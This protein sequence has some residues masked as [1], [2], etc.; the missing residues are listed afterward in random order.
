M[1]G[2]AVGL[3]TKRRV[4]VVLTL[5]EGPEPWIRVQHA[6][7][8]F[9]VPAGVEASELLLGALEGWTSQ[10]GRPRSAETM[11]RVPL[12]EWLRRA[13]AP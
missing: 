9:K 3:R 11:V 12:S 6:R 4:Q 8:W 2:V 10:R 1:E 7:G 13:P 5:M